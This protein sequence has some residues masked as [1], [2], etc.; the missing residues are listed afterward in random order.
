MEAILVA[1]RA[2]FPLV[3]ALN[4][5]AFSDALARAAY[6]GLGRVD[7]ARRY[8][9]KSFAALSDR[10]RRIAPER[11][12]FARSLALNILNVLNRPKAANIAFKLSSSLGAD[13]LLR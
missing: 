11:L 7:A 12:R 9:T 13:A 10:K 3:A 2:T 5:A 1:S 6:A 4:A 8:E